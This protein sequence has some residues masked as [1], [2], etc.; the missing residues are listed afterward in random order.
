[1]GGGRGVENNN[2]LFTISCHTDDKKNLPSMGRMALNFAKAYA[3]FKLHGSPL[4]SEA[5]MEGR[6]DV[7]GAVPDAS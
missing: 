2:G 7:C 3:G 5:E 4:V 1:M 6:L